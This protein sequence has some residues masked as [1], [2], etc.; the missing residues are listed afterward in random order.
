MTPFIEQRFHENA[1]VRAFAHINSK[2]AK[3]FAYVSLSTR[4][5]AG[6]SRTDDTMQTYIVS[7]STM[8]QPRRCKAQER[9]IRDF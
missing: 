2:Y 6:H 7:A 4:D 5:I 1:S 3:N 8:Y 9:I